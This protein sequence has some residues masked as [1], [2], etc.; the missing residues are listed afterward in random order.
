MD[1]DGETVPDPHAWQDPRNAMIY[2][3]NVAAGLISADPANA[4]QYRGGARGFIASLNLIDTWIARQMAAIPPEKRQIVTTHDAFGYFAARYGI[5]LHAIEGISTE[6]EPSAAALAGLSRAIKAA[7]VRAV[8]LENV[9]NPRSIRALAEDTG[10]VIGGT[11]YSDALT[12]PDG[13]A[14]TYMDMLRHNTQTLIRGMA[15]N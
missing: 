15:Q 10:A 9:T 3:N 2:A 1:E 5:A 6:S 12:P 14:P 11:L 8:F 13:P 7:H 4:M